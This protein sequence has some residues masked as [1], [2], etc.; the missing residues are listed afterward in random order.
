LDDARGTDTYESKTYE[1]S[2]GLVVVAL[3]DDALR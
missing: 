1:A 2:E 3:S